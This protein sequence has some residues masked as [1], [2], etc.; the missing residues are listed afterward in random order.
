MKVIREK[1]NVELIFETYKV[2]VNDPKITYSKFCIYILGT[3]VTIANAWKKASKVMTKY[4]KDK[5]FELTGL[6]PSE[7]VKIITKNI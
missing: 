5:V 3:S 4:K 1:I 2:K 6:S 7:Y